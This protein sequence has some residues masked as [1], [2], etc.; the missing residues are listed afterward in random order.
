M[1]ATEKADNEF[2]VRYAVVEKTLKLFRLERMV[3]I[4]FTT[5][6]FLLLLGSAVFLIIKSHA[7]PAI[8]VSLFGSSGVMGFTVG[9][10]LNMWTQALQAITRSGGQP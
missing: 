8:L 9:R 6:S 7:E 3:Y 10:V 5:S 1:S 4:V 2:E